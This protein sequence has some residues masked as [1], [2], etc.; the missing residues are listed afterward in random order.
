M[1]FEESVRAYWKMT[2]DTPR[3][4][5]ERFTQHVLA[6]AERSCEWLMRVEH[7]ETAA[8]G[9][10]WLEL[11]C[12]TGD[13]L[14]AAAPRGAAVVGIDIAL[15]WLVIARK[16]PELR[17]AAE[18][19]VCCGAEALPFAEASFARVLSLGLLEHCAR[20]DAVLSE[21]RRVLKPGGVLRLRTLN[22]YSLLPEPH[23]GVWG[24]G[25]IPRKQADRYVRWRSGQRYLHHRPLSQRELARALQGAD[26][27]QVRVA[28]APL[29]RAEAHR[30]GSAAARLAPLY[31]RAR[32]TPLLREPL[33]WVAPLLEARGTK[34]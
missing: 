1:D 25:F 13:L 26:L 29:L 9:G 27:R 28:A 22:R 8:P 21:A 17:N 33:G 2:P 10:T 23:V 6:A 24:V 34:R 4:L 14:A 15:R 18:Q 19:L 30:L 7:E 3:P 11:G 5:A 12:G 20:P 32:R 31:E 16:R